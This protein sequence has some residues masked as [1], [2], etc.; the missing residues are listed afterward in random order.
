MMKIPMAMGTLLVVS[1]VFSGAAQATGG[2][3]GPVG[4]HLAAAATKSK[5]PSGLIF[6]QQSKQNGDA[7]QQSK[8]PDHE[9][10]P[11]CRYRGGED[12]QLI[13]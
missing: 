8:Q 13:V 1:L 11:G 3:A 10:V 4:S 7:E 2:S 12:L 6:V 9:T 5:S